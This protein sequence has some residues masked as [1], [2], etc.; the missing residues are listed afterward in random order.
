MAQLNEEDTPAGGLSPTKI[1]KPIFSAQ[2]S[3]TTTAP[4][5]EQRQD[6]PQPKEPVCPSVVEEP[7]RQFSIKQNITPPQT[8]G[9]TQATGKTA[10]RKVSFRNFG[11]AHKE[12]ESIK[13]QAEP[14]DLPL[15]PL[16]LSTTRL[17]WQKYINLMPDRLTAMAQRMKTMQ[18]DIGT[19]NSIIVNV[20][21]QQVLA[22]LESM[23]S[24]LERFMHKELRNRK[25]HLIFQQAETEKKTAYSKTDHIMAL[26]KRNKFIAQLANAL[27]LEL[28]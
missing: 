23:R 10:L 21:N 24:N 26:S 1:L 16:D 25:A 19:D 15:T 17:A 14:E 18:P 22:T 11:T 2:A 5:A 7:S 28:D 12:D 9:D 6:Y 27:E 3:Q 13:K 4:K 8:E 20:S